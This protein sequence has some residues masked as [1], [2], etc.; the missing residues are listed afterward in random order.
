MTRYAES[1]NTSWTSRHP[2]LFAFIG[3]FIFLALVAAIHSSRQQSATASVDSASS[4][5]ASAL[6]EKAIKFAAPVVI[7]EISDTLVREK[8]TTLTPEQALTM[9]HINWGLTARQYEA[10][11]DA[12][13]IAADRNYR[14]Q[15]L[16]VTGRISSIDMDFTGDGVITLQGSGLM[17]VHATLSD[18][19]KTSAASLVKG[20]SISLVC[21]G[22]I[23]VA[24]ISSLDHC[25]LAD[26]YFKGQRPS[27]E[28]DVRDFIS[29]KFM[30]PKDLGLS[31][32]TLYAVA[33]ASLVPQACL[34]GSDEECNSALKQTPNFFK[35]LSTAQQQKVKQ[36]VAELK[37]VLKMS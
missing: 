14:G 32:A 4:N 8:K 22:G 15:K 9:M 33:E 29:G 11:Y 2:R 7:D 21:V 31:V 10:E 34:M 16:L 17:G 27:I 19:A 13:E 23:R 25:E 12:N 20:R 3:L 30:L 35:N 1:T 18:K 28:Q 6:N 37:P 26:D 5:Q 24:S 36:R